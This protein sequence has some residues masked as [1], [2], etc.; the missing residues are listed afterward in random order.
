MA[1][2]PY[3][4]LRAGTSIVSG[5]YPIQFAPAIGGKST[6]RGYPWRRFAGDAAANGGAELRVP[7]G[8]FEERALILCNSLD[9][10]HWSFA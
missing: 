10:D 1:S 7:L 9:K 5:G 6:L 3:L 2:G 8:T 4:A